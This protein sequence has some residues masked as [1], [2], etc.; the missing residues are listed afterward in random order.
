M[1]VQLDLDIKFKFNVK[2]T[3]AR[4]SIHDVNVDKDRITK[5]ALTLILVTIYRQSNQDCLLKTIS[6]PSPNID[7][8]IKHRE[9]F[10]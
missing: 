8:R 2:F 6:N 9:M 1:I 10:K 7:D 3:S 4:S 5:R